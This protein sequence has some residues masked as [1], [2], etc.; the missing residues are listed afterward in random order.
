MKYP[1]QTTMTIVAL[2]LLLEPFAI[3]AS[4]DDT[5]AKT[6]LRVFE[7][8]HVF[9]LEYA[10]NPRV[11]PNGQSLVYVRRSYDIMTDKARSNLWQV[12]LDG[13]EHRPLF[14]NRNNF[15]S[16]IWSPDG[17]RI[18]YLS[19]SEGSTQVYVRW[20][21]TGQTALLTNIN[22]APSSLSWSPDGKWLAFTMNVTAK[23]KPLV[24]QRKK[25]KGAKWSKPVK[26]IDTVRYQFDGRGIVEAEYRHIFIIP[27]DGGSP[28]QLTKGNYNH[29]DS[30]S[31]SAD[32]RNILFAANRDSDWELQTIESDIYSVNIVSGDIRQITTGADSERNPQFSPKGDLIAFTLSENKSL[33]Y[34]HAR[35]VVSKPDGSAKKVLSSDL[36]LS[37]SN[38]KW[39]ENGR[40]I[41]FQ[42]DQ[43]AT[44]KVGYLDLKGNMTEIATGLGGTTIGRP[45]LSGSYDV[46]KQNV[47]FT[48]G[49]NNR[50]ADIVIKRKDKI[51]RVTDLNADLLA[52]KDLAQ[53]HELIYSSSFDDQ[54]I[55]G[56]YLTPPGFDPAKQYPMILEIHGGPHSA[57]GPYFSA[58]LQLMA[59]AGYVVFYDN[60][61]GSTSY[62]EK[63][64]LL[65]HHKYASREDFADHM[66]GVD[67]MIEKGFIDKDNLFI[68][69]GSAGGI[70]TAYAIG[71]TNRFNAAVAAKP[72][73]NWISKTLTAD[74]SIYQIRHQFPGM[75]WDNMAHYWERSPLSLVGN[76]TT[77]TMLITGESDRRTPIS[78]T[79]QY[80]QALKLLK[81]DTVMVRIPGAA[82]GIAG[83]PSR[84]IAKL[85][86]ILAW[87]K[88]YRHDPDKIEN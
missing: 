48:L 35:L 75:P 14:S 9:D 40:G 34:R 32:G 19:S 77:P 15:H 1:S 4:S 29:G 76:V 18:A 22:K 3:Y 27:S 38:I 13:S 11:H 66:S 62:G 45:Y 72:V 42:Y 82:H 86:N 17:D 24:K 49:K 43:R 51:N 87:F 23:T 41:Y 64:A 71:L 68:A 20:M 10:S 81:V 80:Y 58:E 84:L 33:A 46:S 16:P 74:S 67:A 21:D 65:L 36:D 47:A 26:V 60:H 39:A 7:A 31:W 44:R 83:R 63:F 28:R 50:P 5:G 69:G 12:N 73:I 30:L 56:W 53:I 37:V 59:A 8:D 78:E 79:E 25:P 57:Y 6:N 85:D 88:R 61:R 54:E 2:I 52:H 55:Q 70:A